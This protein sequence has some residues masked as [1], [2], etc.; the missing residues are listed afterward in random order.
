MVNCEFHLLV[1]LPVSAFNGLRWTALV[2]TPTSSGFADVS[3]LRMDCIYLSQ[4]FGRPL[5]RLS[6]PLRRFY[7]HR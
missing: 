1:P 3:V 5:V 6:M 7:Q 4:K 2:D